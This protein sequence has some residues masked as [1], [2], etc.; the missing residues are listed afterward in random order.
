MWRAETKKKAE[1]NGS[2]VLP[3]A[4]VD[5]CTKEMRAPHM[6][7]ATQIVKDMRDKA[8]EAARTWR[9]MNGST[10]LRF[11]KQWRYSVLSGQTLTQ[12]AAYV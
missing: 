9:R 10:L 8:G 2:V 6:E 12:P 3:Q 1:N 7:E 5:V 4:Y 11:I